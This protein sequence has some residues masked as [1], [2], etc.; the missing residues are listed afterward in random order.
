MSRLPIW[1]P[2]ARGD[3]KFV[4]HC[5][6]A[7]GWFDHQLATRYTSNTLQKM[8]S[9]TAVVPTTW[10][11]E[12][13]GWFL[14]AEAKGEAWTRIDTFLRALCPLSIRLDRQG[15][16]RAWGRILSM[17]RAQSVPVEAAGYLELAT[18]LHLPIAT[19]DPALINA[20]GNVGVAVFTP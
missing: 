18:R 11:V 6:V 3:A 14:Q 1:R 19:V 4:L 7:L 8:I 17:A 5:S 9:T 13:A 12:L 10:P 15:P 16:L 20:A 2:N